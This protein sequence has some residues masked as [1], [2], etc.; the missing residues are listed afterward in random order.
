[1]G[2]LCGGAAAGCGQFIAFYENG[3]GNQCGT[4]TPVEA[5]GMSA[6][7]I[8][9]GFNGQNWILGFL[10]GSAGPNDGALKPMIAQNAFNFAQLE[11]KTPSWQCAT[12]YGTT[13]ALWGL[14]HDLDANF[15]P[16]FPH[17]RPVGWAMALDNQ[18]IG[19]SYHLMNT[20]NFPGVYGAAFEVGNTW[21]ALLSNSNNASVSIPIT[22]PSG[23]LPAA[24]Y[25][26]QYTNSISDNNENSGSVFI[27]TLPGG[28]APLNQ[29]ITVTLP[30]LSLVAVK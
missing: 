7:W 30:A 6:G 3:N 9:A 4:A 26:V 10:T 13:S 5:Y 12:G 17:M 8:P 19:G 29:T 20:A 21:R 15:G 11:F 24:A 28:L 2:Q 22:F 18:V 27:G 1:V 23:T 25:T 16:K 14:V